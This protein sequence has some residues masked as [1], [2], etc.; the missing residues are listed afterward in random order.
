MVNAIKPNQTDRILVLDVVAQDVARRRLWLRPGQLVHVGRTER[1]DEC[2]PMDVGMSS[3]HFLVEHTDSGWRCRDLGSTNGTFL[4]DALIAEAIIHPGDRIRA[5]NTTFV[6]VSPNETN[7]VGLSNASPSIEPK[8]FSRDVLRKP[9]PYELTYR[10]YPGRSEL[11]LFVSTKS[12]FDPVF[13]VRSMM[14]KAAPLVLSM[15]QQ[16]E[17][18]CPTVKQSFWMDPRPGEPAECSRVILQP[19]S[20]EAWSEMLTARWGCDEVVIC[21]GVDRVESAIESIRALARAAVEQFGF[22]P[23]AEMRP[24]AIGEYLV[25]QTSTQ[26]TALFA[27]GGCEFIFLELFRGE[28]WGIIAPRGRESTLFDLGFCPAQIWQS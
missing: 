20:A 11:V 22:G 18:L 26:A 15:R 3:R 14:K 9:R 19:P 24:S 1:A 13:V 4:N 6:V 8:T 27:T 28:R 5:G 2:F 17:L 23:L 10:A 12:N 25:N 16:A 21:T 7:I